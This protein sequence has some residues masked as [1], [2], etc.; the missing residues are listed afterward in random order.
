MNSGKI[1]A[2]V[3]DRQ[4]TVGAR[5][6]NAFESWVPYLVICGDE[7]TKYGIYKLSSKNEVVAAGSIDE[8]IGILN[9]GNEKW[10][11]RPWPGVL[12]S[13]IPAFGK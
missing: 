13:K 1:R 11:Y 7:E 8:L 6:R 4:K 12:V 9:E 3:D 5:I 2:D 10:P